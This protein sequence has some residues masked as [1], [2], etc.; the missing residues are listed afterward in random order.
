MF[1]LFFLRWGTL[2]RFRRVK[3]FVHALIATIPTRRYTICVIYY[4]TIFSRVIL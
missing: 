1:C 2:K 3:R 4:E